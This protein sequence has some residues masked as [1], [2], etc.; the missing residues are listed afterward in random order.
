M[1]KTKSGH[2]WTQNKTKKIIKKKLK[3]KN[4]QWICS[5]TTSKQIFL[6][7][8]LSHHWP[9]IGSLMTRLETDQPSR[10]Y[11]QRLSIKN[12]LAPASSLTSPLLFSLESSRRTLAKSIYIGGCKL[13]L[14]TTTKIILATVIFFFLMLFIVSCLPISLSS[15]WLSLPLACPFLSPLS[16]SPFLACLSFWFGGVGLWVQFGLLNGSLFNGLI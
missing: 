9:S 10:S 8:S 7:F 15:L 6:S 4:Y 2:D 16:N 12:S 11:F 5:L 3:R 14:V 1:A 13:Q